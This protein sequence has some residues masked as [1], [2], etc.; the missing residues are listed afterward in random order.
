MEKKAVCLLSGGLDSCVASFLAKHQGFSCYA[1]SFDYG[2]RHTCELESARKIAK[3]LDAVE[4]RVFHIDLQQ[5]GG[6][7]LV[8][9]SADI[10]TTEIQ[11]IGQTIP[12]TYVPARNTIFLSFALA[13]A[14]T[15][16]ADA[17]F[18]GANALDFSGYPDCRPE[19]FQ[20]FQHLATLATK[21]TIEGHPITIHTP[22][23]H[24]TKKEIIKKG[25][26]V[27]AP[28]YLTWSCYKGEQLACGTCESCQLR[29]KGFQEAGLPDP[30]P[31]AKY[32]LWYTQ[33][34]K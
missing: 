15:R 30:L 6:S 26:E 21:Q 19:Y 23:L 17:I 32:P 5:F 8:D 10:P 24:L 3:A 11:S 2:Q 28:L 33:K 12:S 31:Y 18:I 4:H 22:L 34:K 13:F 25:K 27:D 16:K 9:H 29:L 14:E 7:S 1:L 20:A